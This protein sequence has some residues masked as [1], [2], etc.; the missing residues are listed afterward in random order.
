MKNLLTALCLLATCCA[1][2]QTLFTY[3]KESVSA[4]DFLRAFKKNNNGAKDQKAL[5]EYLNLYIASRLKIEEAKEARFDTLPQLV[6]DLANLRQQILPGYLNDKESL[7]KLVTEAFSRSQKDLHIAHIFIAF[8]KADADAAAAGKKRDEVT[9]KL[10]KGAK[11]DE[12][13]KQYSDDPSAKNNGGDLGWLTVFSLPYQLE[14]IVYTTPVGK[15]S[16]V[17]TSRAGYHIFK[18]LGER[19]AAGRLRVAQ[20][21][22]AFPPGIDDAGKAAIKKKADSLYAHLLAGDDFGRLATAYS[23]D[24]VSSASNGQMSEFGVGEYDPLFESAVFALTK[25]GSTTKPFTTSHGYHIVK[26]LK[27]A[28][29]ATKLD[30]A[31]IEVLQRKIEGNDRIATTKNILA[32]KVVKQ[33]GY[34]R[35]LDSNDE[36]WAYTDSVLSYVH[37]K[38]PLSINNVTGLL[39]IGDRTASVKD[40]TNF[41]Q[42]ARYRPD[43]SGVKS[44]PA[45]WEEFVQ[46]KALEYY[47]DHLENFNEDFR[48][49]ITEFADGNLFF[50]IMQRN[51]WTPA[52]TD[53]IALLNYYQ[54][55]KN[56]YTWKQ[57]ADAVIFYA[58]NE[59]AGNDFFKA[60]HQQATSWRTALSNYSE[61]ITAD[62]SRF[63]LSQIPKG[64]GDIVTAGVLTS[65]VIN[66]ADNTSSFAY[67]IALHTKEEPRNFTEAK[68]MVINDYQAELEKE[69]LVK[70][71]KKY[72]VQVNESV[73][74]EVLRKKG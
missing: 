73:W 59:Q 12:V 8:G 6:S 62:S 15:T 66:K 47:Q 17:Y 49:Q 18:N 60:L 45:L 3:G 41:A 64:A 43:G 52:Q 22:L 19:K 9:A 29:V 74:R 40:W 13:A 27:A 16:A 42:T 32:Q 70:L 2:A 10:A 14:N 53:S 54:K 58:A 63:E 48:K 11:F 26:R 36:L 5:N 46:A 71:K 72:P 33:A 57:S 65:P 50:E 20:I 37:P 51:V 68:G 25:D 67:V 7:N 38:K 21:L 31:T 56:N 55:H 61:Q 1:N 69:W 34:K 35:L 44:Y 28:P 4:D 23:N 39:K 24:V 30:A